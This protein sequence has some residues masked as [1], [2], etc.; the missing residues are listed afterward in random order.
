ME[1]LLT[2]VTINPRG[3]A[4]REQRRISGAVLRLGRGT[5]CEIHLPDSRV[6]LIHAR[7]TATESGAAIETESGQ[8]VVNGRDVVRVN[9]AVGDRVEIG[10]YLIEVE[11][12]PANLQLALSVQLVSPFGKAEQGGRQR[13]RIRAPQISIRRLSYLAFGGVLSLFLLLPVAPQLLQGAGLLSPDDNPRQD[14][15]IMQTLSAAFLQTWNPGPLSRGHQVFA[16]N[17]GAC[18]ALPFIQV[19]DAECIACHKDT[20]EHVAASGSTGHQGVVRREVRCAECHRDHKDASMITRAQDECSTCHGDNK[21]A[22]SGDSTRKV[23]DFAVDHPAF[24]LTLSD[25]NHPAKSRR[26]R[27]GT[28][29]SDS[30]VERSN[31]KFNHKLHL[32]P[33]GIRDPQGKRNAA[34]MRDARGGRTVLDCASCHQPESDGGRMTPVS[35]E[36]HCQSC[37]SLAF[38][39]TV[40]SRQVPHGSEE[41]IV[42]M[43]REFYARL[44]LGD[45]PKGVTPPSDLPRKRPGA[46]LSPA[47]SRRALQLAD[48]KAQRILHDL[49]ERRQ[50]CSTCHQVSQRSDAGWTVAPVAIARQWMPAAKFSHAKHAT[51]SCASCHNVTTSAAAE[52]IAM[53][54]IAKCRECH[55][56]ARPV[57]NRVTSDCAICH[58]F[59]AGSGYWHGALHAGV[60]AKR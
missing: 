30:L 52:D 45:T 12:P 21:A 23:T 56:G 43:L 13:L 24:R 60:R 19:R 25:A 1:T 36:R 37:H 54:D 41:A 48:H 39:P 5:Q 59:H 11:T 27:Q 34:G 58:S 3:Q 22:F 26:V 53:P 4:M 15:G 40:T 47:E 38:E 6:A 29:T 46:E 33:A 50:V 9:L 49:F 35:M 42:T 20:R 31:L 2:T 8:L 16:D 18:H 14:D 51:Q 32:D 17:C 44:V 57:H 7:L 28:E 55:V 10:P